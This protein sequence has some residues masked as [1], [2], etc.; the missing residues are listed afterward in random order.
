VGG[1]YVRDVPIWIQWSKVGGGLTAWPGWVAPK[2]PLPP[3]HAA[4]RCHPPPHTHTHTHT[5]TPPAA[6]PL[7]PPSQYLS[8]VYWGFNL[9]LKVEFGGRS[10]V[11]CT[12]DSGAAGVAACA[13]VEDLQAALHL[14]S[15]PNDS[16]AIDAIVL[17]ANLVLL[18]L[19]VYMA[20]RKKTKA[21]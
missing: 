14:P 18:R 15:N 13:P 3:C 20:L 21:S 2:A 19:G 9:L 4:I 11:S 12:A 7:S 6:R 8:F 17:V 5:H 10:F 1:F 16:A